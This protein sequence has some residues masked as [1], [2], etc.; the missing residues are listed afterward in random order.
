MPLFSVIIPTYNRAELLCQ[1]LNSVFA[2]TFTDFEVIVVD[3]GSTDNTATSIK[4]YPNHVH[5]LRQAN[6]GPGA[7][8]NLGI[9]N[10]QG[11][12]V[13]FIDSD[14]IWFPWTLELYRQAI[15]QAS[16][17]SFVAGQAVKF[18]ELGELQTIKYSQPSIALFPDYLSTYR[19]PIWIGT[20]A[21]AIHRKAFKDVGGFAGLN[22]NAEDSDL[23]L[24]LGTSMGFAWITDPPMFGYRHT[25]RS[26]VSNSHRTYSGIKHIIATENAGKYPGG[27]N[28][29]RE[30]VTF[31]TLHS[32]PAS[33]S[34]IYGKEFR[35]AQDLYW[36]SLRWNLLL[37]RWKYLIGFWIICFRRMLTGI[38]GI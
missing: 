20:C 25:P 35:K 32:R 28:R 14:D 10:A 7:A 16:T 11:E 31:I 5:F 1:S 18:N 19:R 22:I 3:D 33:L 21:V 26:A 24:K 17:I 12:Y 36:A 8:R 34:L 15:T 2:Q 9:Q 13:A 6:K 29:C 37:G 23:W 38:A 30:R 4:Y 27:E